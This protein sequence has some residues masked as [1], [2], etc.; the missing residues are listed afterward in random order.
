MFPLSMTRRALLGN[1]AAVSALAAVPAVAL[2]ATESTTPRAAAESTTPRAAA[3][4]DTALAAALATIADRLLQRS[5]ESATLLGMDTGHNAALA[6]KLSDISAAGEAEDRRTQA[7]A[8]R[9]LDTIPRDRLQGADINN[10]DSAQWALGIAAEG[11]GFDFG[12]S[13]TSGGI[14][15]VVSQQN[16]TYQQAAEFLDTY[17]RVED[18][19]GLEA[20]FSRLEQVAPTL[21]EETRRIAADAGKGIIPPAFIN[22]NTL[23][24]QAQL[25]AVPVADSKFVTSI[26]N[27]AKKLGLPDPS[28]RASAI[29][30]KAIYPALDAQMVALKALKTNDDAGM[31]KLPNGDAY[32]QYLLKSQTTTSLSA[33]EIH[34]TGWE[35]NRAIEAEMDKILRAQGLT[36]GSVGERAAALTADKRFVQPDSDA[37]RAAVLAAC[38]KVID[39]IRPR[40][41]RI[42]KLGLKAE[43]Q[44]KRVPVD[45]QDGAG[46]GYMNFA[47]TDGKRPAIYYINLKQMDYWPS[48][49]LASLTAHEA[50]PGHAWQ[51]AYLAEHPDIVSPMAQLIGFNAF[52]EGW[53]LYAEQLV[54]ED[55][56]YVDDPLGRLGYLNAQRFRAVRLIVDTGMHAMKWSRDKAIATMVAETGR[57]VGSVTSEI[58]RYCASPGQACGYKIGHNEILKQRARAATVLGPKFDVR[59]FNDALVATGGVPLSA[60]PG[61]VDRMIAAVKG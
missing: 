46:L 42:S 18:A 54:D 61:V 51:G 56:L 33:A 50:I 8:K 6:G 45:I 3:G 28:A 21:A 57:S 22:A 58:D 52:V 41:G 13:G 30:E 1:T 2:A 59:D 32:Y 49:T 39:D 35:Q 14:P 17:H 4:G 5:P 7:T 15:Y 34:Q 23:G 37:G 11:A 40:L 38:Q 24:Q 36:Q 60:L 19:A 12:F 53:A 16:G 44:V 47:S 25:R 55:G 9:L 26:A 29:V 27:R 48:W 10:Y 43:V 20:Y 31:W